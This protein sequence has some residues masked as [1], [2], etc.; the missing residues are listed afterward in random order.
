M[1]FVWHE[2]WRYGTLNVE[3]IPDGMTQKGA[4]Y[5]RT[6]FQHLSK[7]TPDLRC[8]NRPAPWSDEELKKGYFSQSGISPVVWSRYIDKDMFQLVAL[9]P[10]LPPKEREKIPAGDRLLADD[11]KLVTHPVNRPGKILYYPY[12]TIVAITAIGFY[13]LE[14][15][16]DY[17]AEN[18]PEDMLEGANL[19]RAAAELCGIFAWPKHTMVPGDG[20]TSL[21]KSIRIAKDYIVKEGYKIVK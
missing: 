8:L 13:A 20:R 15:Y 10:F 14:D 3:N 16:T 12:Q 19:A 5:A 2:K 6:I 1:S 21:G 18:Y 4:E 9:C 7:D 11:L 17:L